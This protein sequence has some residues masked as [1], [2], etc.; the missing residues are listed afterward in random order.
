M[1]AMGWFK[2]IS[3]LARRDRVTREIDREL[4]F[5]LDELAD[6]LMAEGMSEED[7]R[8]EARRRFG[9]PTVQRER[10]RDVD[11]MVWLESI[12]ADLRYALR[13]LRGSPGFALAAVLSLALGIGANTAIFSLVDAVLLRSL[14]VNRP[15][16]LRQL[17][18]GGGDV[19]FTN[20]AWEEIRDRQ[21]AFSQA[22]AYS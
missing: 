1:P 19:T 20:P 2:R 13:S 12:G 18:M 17:S 10:T 14:P 21:D 8:R 22:T 4:G 16:E 15:E 3:N 11:L 6:E 5:H 9:N 7:A